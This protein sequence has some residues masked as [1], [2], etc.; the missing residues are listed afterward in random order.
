M[1]DF[2]YGMKAEKIAELGTSFWRGRWECERI[3]RRQGHLLLQ[4]EWLE[5]QRSAE[6][7]MGDRT[8]LDNQQ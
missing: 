3:L 1:G 7:T 6:K 2:R 5:R 8:V 4:T